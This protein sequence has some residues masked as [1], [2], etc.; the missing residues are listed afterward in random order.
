MNPHALVQ[1]IP[2]GVER[3]LFRIATLGRH[4]VDVVVA[5]ILPGECDPLSIRREFR[6]QLLPGMARD[7]LRCPT[8]SRD[9][10]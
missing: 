6:K 10:P 5:V 3:Q 4:D 2:A 9:Q 7:S 1:M 8:L